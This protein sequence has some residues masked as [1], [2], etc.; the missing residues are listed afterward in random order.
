MQGMNGNLMAR[1]TQRLSFL[2]NP[3]I[4]AKFVPNDHGYLSHTT[5]QYKRPIKAAPEINQ[6]KT[7]Y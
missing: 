7:D 4:V 2:Q 3:R 6:L 1:P 5:S